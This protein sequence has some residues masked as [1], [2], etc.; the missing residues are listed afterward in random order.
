MQGESIALRATP[1]E[2]SGATCLWRR[3]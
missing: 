3:L 1:D 2:A